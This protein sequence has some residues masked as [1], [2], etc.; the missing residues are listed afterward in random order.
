MSGPMIHKRSFRG[1]P[2]GS[3][4]V[5]GYARTI[6]IDG[7]GDLAVWYEV[8]PDNVHG[9]QILWTGQELEEGFTVIST[10]NTGG[11]V[12]HLA[13]PMENVAGRS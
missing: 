3:H 2:L 5:G 10:C 6:G 4:T 9:Y 1:A 13:V 11:F 12:W 7:N 8:D